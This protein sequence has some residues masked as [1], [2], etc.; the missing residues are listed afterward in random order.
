MAEDRD[1]TAAPRTRRGLW[2]GWYVQFKGERHWFSALPWA[3]AEWLRR[4]EAVGLCIG[5][6]RD[7]GK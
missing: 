3:N 7:L 6:P 4:L 1:V 5:E 2:N